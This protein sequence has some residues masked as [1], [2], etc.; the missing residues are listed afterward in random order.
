MKC[1][2]VLLV[3]LLFFFSNYIYSFQGQGPPPPTIPPP[4]GLPATINDKI[5]FLVASAI[6]LGFL[7]VNKKKA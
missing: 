7:I 3:F 1:K 6:L 5:L 4:V 2:M